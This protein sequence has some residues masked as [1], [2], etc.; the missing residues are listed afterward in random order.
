[1]S[2]ETAKTPTRVAEVEIEAADARV[3]VRITGE[4]ADPDWAVARAREL[5]RESRVLDGRT[6]PAAGFVSQLSPRR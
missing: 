4:T 2:D 6:Y 5:W 1:M 3:K